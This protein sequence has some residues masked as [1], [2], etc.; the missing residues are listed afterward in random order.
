MAHRISRA[1]ICASCIFTV[2]VQYIQ[3]GKGKENSYHCMRLC[4]NASGFLKRVSLLSAH[5]VWGSLSLTHS[6]SPS[7]LR[8]AYCSGE[9][10]P[11]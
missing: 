8:P 1:G 7:T 5:Q 3:G 4:G 10:S 2:D 6:P 9:S 11:V